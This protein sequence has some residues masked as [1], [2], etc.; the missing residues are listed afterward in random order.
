MKLKNRILFRISL[1]SI[2]LINCVSVF[3]RAGGDSSGKMG[4]WAIVLFIIF[5]PFFLIYSGI[6]KF[7]TSQRKKSATNLINKLEATDNIWNERSMAARA[8]EVFLTVQKAWTERNM[9]IAREH[10]SDRLYTKYKFQTDDM[11]TRGVKNYLQDIKLEPVT[12]FSVSDYKDNNKDS[13]S[14][15][16]GGRML[17]YELNESTNMVTKGDRNGPHY[18]EDIWTFIR[19]GN[20]WI[21]DDVDNSVSL[22]DIRKGTAFSEG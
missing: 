21:A 3:A 19:K 12:I 6:V 9:D 4:F 13:F 8:E 10:V 11:T 17:D 22:G 5:L 7:F 20:T 2:F 14:A 1:L 18:F 16:I 15:K